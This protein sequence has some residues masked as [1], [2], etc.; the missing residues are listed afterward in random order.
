MLIAARN[1]EA[2]LPQ[3]LWSINRQDY[4]AS[5]ITT[6][7]VADNCTDDTARVAEEYGA[8]VYRRFH[9]QKVGKGHA[10][11]DLLRWLRDRPE[12]PQIDAF[13]I[14]DAD[15]LLEPDYVR[16]INRTCSDGYDAFCGYRNSKNFGSSW[17]SAG[18]AVW[19]LH[20]CVHLSRSRQLTNLPCAVTGTGFGFT[21]DLLE[22]MGGWNFFT[23]T[24]D[25]QFSFWCAAHVI[26]VGYCHDAVLYDEQPVTLRQSFRQ[27]IRW[28]QGTMQVSVCLGPDLLKGL[29][30][31][32]RTGLV[33][34]Q[35][36]SLSMW[37]FGLSGVVG[38]LGFVTAWLTHGVQAALCSAAMGAI[39]MLLI[40]LLTAGLTLLTERKRI[41][42]TGP[43][44][45]M[46]LLVFPL[47]MLCY[48][49]IT[50]AA[51]FRKRS[52]KPIAHSAVR[53]EQLLR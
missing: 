37:G 27:R 15:N 11:H 18:H 49:P 8:V 19:F 9:T 32:G 47:Y 48:V 34:L 20:E 42:A 45:L 33:C 53:S 35:N 13:L 28:V 6:Y 26:R 2:V 43:Q 29:I 12:Y 10:L 41:R 44:K 21:R 22:T 50:V 39:G 38:V 25:I 24:E 36:L 16:S 17:V 3:L 52:W 46:G 31:G 51:I 14:F 4:P 23:L 30:R 5:L 1:E 7:V 40:L